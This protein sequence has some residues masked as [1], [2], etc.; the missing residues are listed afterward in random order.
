MDSLS[1]FDEEMKQE[2]ETEV[3][4][5]ER[6]EIR[7]PYAVWE[8]DEREYKLKLTTGVICRLEDKYRRNLLQVITSDD[9]P[10]LS[11]MLTVIQGGMQK[12]HHGIES[13]DVQKIYD[14]YLAEGGSQMKLLSDVI[15]PL[16]AVSGFFTESQAKN[17]QEKLDE[18]DEAF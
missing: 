11:V 1:G 18:A 13:K 12:Y 15:M 2:T 16:L 14:K 9:I 3:D 6:K 5:V 8:V 10:P 17:L 7:K 4:F